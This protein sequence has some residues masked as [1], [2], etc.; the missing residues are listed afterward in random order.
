MLFSLIHCIFPYLTKNMFR[1]VLYRRLTTPKS[2]IMT[3][4]LVPF[5][6]LLYSCFYKDK[7]FTAQEQY[8]HPLLASGICLFT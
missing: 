1:I 7:L 6:V 4:I 3:A 5:S 2:D 8:D